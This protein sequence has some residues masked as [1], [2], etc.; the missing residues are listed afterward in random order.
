MINLRRQVPSRRRDHLPGPEAA[1]RPSVQP[2]DRLGDHRQDH[3]LRHR[4]V[5]LQHGSSEL[6]GHSRSGS[7]PN[8]S[9]PPYIIASRRRLNLIAAHLAGFR[10]PEVARGNV[11]YNQRADVFSLGLLLYDLLTCGERISDGMKFPSEFDEVVVQG[12]LPGN[13]QRSVRHSEFSVGSF[14]G[15]QVSLIRHFSVLVPFPA[16]THPVQ[17]N[18]SLRSLSQGSFMLP[19]R[20]YI[21][22]TRPFQTMLSPLPT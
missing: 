22:G 14:L 8:L 12:K 18:D 2:E 3:R 6:G 17:A 11:T 13:N 7:S 16:P 15:D 20:T 19:L 21:N 4:S 1:Q 10:A 5:L 9:H